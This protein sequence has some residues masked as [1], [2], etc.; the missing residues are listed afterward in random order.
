MSD[1][2]FSTTKKIIAVLAGAGLLLGLGAGAALYLRV[3]DS[4]PTIDGTA[5]LE[6]LG[7]EVRIER[8]AGTGPAVSPGNS[9]FG[10]RIVESGLAEI[11]ALATLG[12]YSPLALAL[13][14]RA[15]RCTGKAQR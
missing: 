8:D 3:R 7:A 15:L 9:G 4:L 1:K 6:G 13:A 12:A 5:R 2:P 10:R 11:I 14:W